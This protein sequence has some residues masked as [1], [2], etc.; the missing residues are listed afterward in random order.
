MI[1]E[2]IKAKYEEAFATAQEMRSE[3]FHETADQYERLAEK[4]FNE[5]FK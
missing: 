3:G 2:T 5:M 4:L 1:N